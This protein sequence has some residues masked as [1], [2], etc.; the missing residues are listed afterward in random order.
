M[1]LCRRN[2]EFPNSR[3]IALAGFGSVD[4]SQF[5]KI[6]PPG[7]VKWDGGPTT[8]IVGQSS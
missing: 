8:E 4:F 1:L 7:A 5:A 6:R 3:E 2:C